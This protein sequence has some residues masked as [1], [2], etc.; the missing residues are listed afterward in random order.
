MIDPRGWEALEN[1]K[2]PIC[3][4]ISA[5]TVKQANKYI[6]C[7]KEKCMWWS[8]CKGLEEQ[9]PHGEWM[10]GE[11]WSEGIGMGENY[12]QYKICPFCGYKAKEDPRNFCQKCGADMRPK[13]GEAE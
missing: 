3:P 6:E 7:V 11:C 13:E 1:V 12:G 2:N 4:L 9:R 10:L 5:L 8:K